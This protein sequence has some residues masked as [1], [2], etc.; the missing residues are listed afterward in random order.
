MVHYCHC[1]VKLHQNVISSFHVMGNFS[2][3]KAKV[4]Y[5]QNVITFNRQF[6]TSLPSF[7]IVFDFF[8]CTDT[9]RHMELDT[10]KAIPCFARTQAQGSNDILI[11]TAHVQCVHVSL[12]R[13]FHFPKGNYSL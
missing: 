3:S 12:P 8:M 6:N 1:H 4:K 10:T 11:A 13:I 7:S 2:K 9:N 5:Q